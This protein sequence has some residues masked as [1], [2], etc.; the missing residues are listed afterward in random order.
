MDYSINVFRIVK[1]AKPAGTYV[2]RHFHEYFHY[3]YIL[4]GR[5]M[6]EVDYNHYEVN[7]RTLIMVPPGII[8]AIYSMEGHTALDI[9]F[10]C[11]GFLLSQLKNIGYCVT[12]IL[13][14]EDTLLKRIIGEAVQKQPAFNHVINSY[15][16]TI[17]M[18]VLQRRQ[19]GTHMVRT[20]TLKNQLY[21]VH[22]KRRKN[23]HMAL[24]YIENNLDKEIS[25][26]KLAK[27]CNYNE[28][29]FST[30]FKE[31]MGMSPSKYINQ[32]KLDKARFMI[33]GSDKSI[34]Q[35]AEELG[36]N[37]I[38]YFSR[39]FKSETGI[40]PADYRKTHQ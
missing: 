28:H 11:D 1:E 22:Q 4:S 3:I 36:F 23:I 38:H 29:Y 14:L 39:V 9:K 19:I 7:E 16:L 40:L 32:L 26:R 13:D 34:T 18:H 17:L 30:Y 15:F 2:D 25:I 27:L 8:H 37:S 10:T 6:I 35:I 24:E 21:G 31:C 12:D 5:G 20:D 33:V